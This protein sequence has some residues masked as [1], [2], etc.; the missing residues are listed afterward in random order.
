M[1]SRPGVGASE[2]QL[3][4][5]SRHSDTAGAVVVVVARGVV[6]G[7]VRALTSTARKTLLE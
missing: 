6:G 4:D 7:S 3:P 1:Q 5:R 2:T